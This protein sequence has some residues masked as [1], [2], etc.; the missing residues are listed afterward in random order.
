MCYFQLRNIP[1]YGFLYYKQLQSLF[2]SCGQVKTISFE[3]SRYRR[4]L[5]HTS[6]NV[7]LTDV[8]LYMCFSSQ[9]VCGVLEVLSGHRCAA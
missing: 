3:S 2:R 5:K 8:A 7:A 9:S 1:P 4:M 6:H